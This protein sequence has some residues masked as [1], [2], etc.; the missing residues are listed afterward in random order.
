MNRKLREISNIKLSSVILLGIYSALL[1]I[2]PYFRGLFFDADFYKFEMVLVILSLSIIFIYHKEQTLHTFKS[3]LIYPLIGLSLVYFLSAFQGHVGFLAYQEAFRWLVYCLVFISLLIILNVKFNELILHVV[4]IAITWVTIYGLLAQFELVSFKDAVVWE[5]IASV[6]Q[7]PNPLAAIAATGILGILF[8]GINSK[9]KWYFRLTYSALLVPFVIVLIFTQSRATLVMLPV[10]WVVSMFFL[11]FLQQIQYLISTFLLGITSVPMLLIYDNYLSSKNTVILYILIAVGILYSVISFAINM[12][13]ERI[14]VK[15]EPWYRRLIIPLLMVLLA[16]VGFIILSSPTIIK[17]L[18]SVLSDRLSDI[19]LETRSVTE[20]GTFYKDSMKLFLDYPLLGTGGNSW[21]TLYLSYQSLP[22]TST[23]T[24]SFVMKLLD[25]VG[26][27]GFIFLFAF[28]GVLLF[29]FYRWFRKYGL[30]HERLLNV[31]LLVAMAL[32]L[33]VHSI[34]DFDMSYGFFALLWFTLLAMIYVEIR[35]PET[36]FMVRKKWIGTVSY[37]GISVISIVVL[38]FIGMN[39]YAEMIKTGGMVYT[40]ALENIEKRI[41]L[42]PTNV[43]YRFQKMEILEI[44][45]MDTK[46]STK[47]EELLQ[48]ALKVE[49]LDKNN[50]I[51]HIKTGQYFA[52]YGYGKNALDSTKK[53]IDHSP[54]FLVAYEQY[55][56]FATQLST[57]MIK[58]DRVQEASETLQDVKKRLDALESNIA[59]LQTMPESLRYPEFQITDPIRRQGGIALVLL[60]EYDHAKIYLEPLLASTDLQKKEDATLWMSI[61]E[62]KLGNAARSDELVKEG[63]GINAEFE[64]KR[65]EILQ[66]MQKLPI[67]E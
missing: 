25:E 54:W 4:F 8:Y 37:V 2:M 7:Y 22:Y 66:L 62:E 51:T 27:V 44:A 61:L 6:F 32:M 1:L 14:N 23:Q 42:S 56:S 67:Q 17:L 48:E 46:D 20:R 65:T 45:Y 40:K 64:Q 30:R 53:A 59:Y 31:G 33:F 10:V 52:K 49:E 34:V 39:A 58:E 50:P 41:K 13:L 18:P 29:T 15:S 26:L 55:I 57:V 36:E 24:H 28:I 63:L 19:N 16:I 11:N 3:Y 60:G 5:R 47:I 35:E 12:L 9:N 21:K 38:I 43:D